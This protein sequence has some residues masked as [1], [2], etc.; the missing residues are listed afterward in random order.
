MSRKHGDMYSSMA[1]DLV[2]RRR[3]EIDFLAGKVDRPLS[4]SIAE[5]IHGLEDASSYLPPGP[6]DSMES[7]KSQNSL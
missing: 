6:R 4:R 1:Q 7:L 3:T 2:A 5:K